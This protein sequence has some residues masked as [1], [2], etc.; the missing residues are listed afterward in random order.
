MRGNTQRSAF[1]EIKRILQ[2]N[3]VLKTYN[4]KKDAFIFEDASL[5]GTGA[6][7]LQRQPEDNV[8]RLIA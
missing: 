3:T 4:L 6:I 8:F 5:Y 2:S 7:I 1:K